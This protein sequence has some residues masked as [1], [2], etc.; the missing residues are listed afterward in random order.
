[1]SLQEKIVAWVVAIAL[2]AACVAVV[3]G[4]GQ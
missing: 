1:M 4:L 2:F 3:V